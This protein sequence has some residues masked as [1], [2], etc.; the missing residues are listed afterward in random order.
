LIADEGD[1]ATAATVRVG[2]VTEVP[3]S[4]MLGVGEDGYRRALLTGST[5]VAGGT[6]IGAGEAY[7]NDGP[8]DVPDDYNR[9]NAELRYVRGIPGFREPS[10]RDFSISFESRAGST[11]RVLELQSRQIPRA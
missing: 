9:L 4:A 1:F 11:R 7:H 2:L 3:Q 10:G 5:A 6:L 8:F